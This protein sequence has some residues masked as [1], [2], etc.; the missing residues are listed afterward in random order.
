MLFLSNNA[1]IVG[2]YKMYPLYK[3]LCTKC[4][5]LHKTN[6][7][8]TKRTYV[9]RS[10]E[11]TDEKRARASAT[12]SSARTV[13]FSTSFSNNESC[14]N[15]FQSSKNLSDLTETNHQVGGL[16]SSLVSYCNYHT[17]KADKIRDRSVELYCTVS[18]IHPHSPRGRRST[19]LYC[20]SEHVH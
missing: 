15:S 5:F 17:R 10:S 20:T 6:R 18:T 4:S 8:E 12:Y 11:R 9:Y 19:A 13:R 3:I 2:R 14:S 7:N 16:T 1:F